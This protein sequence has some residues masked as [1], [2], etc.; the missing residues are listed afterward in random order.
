MVDSTNNLYDSLKATGLV[1]EEFGTKTYYLAFTSDIGQNASAV[2]GGMAFNGG[3][4]FANGNTGIANSDG[5]V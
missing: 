1:L 2:D 3:G 5:R 4:Y